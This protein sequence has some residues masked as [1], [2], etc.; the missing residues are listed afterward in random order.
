[1]GPGRKPERW[2]SHDAA[3]MFSHDRGHMILFSGYHERLNVLKYTL[4]KFDED[5]QK[6]SHLDPNQVDRAGDSLFHLVAK[7]K[8]NNMVLS[9]TELLCKHNLSS[10]VY[11][12]DQKLPSFYIKKQND[13]RLPFIKL[14][15]KALPKTSG[16]KRKM[17][18]ENNGDEN[19][20]NENVN[21]DT[22]GQ[23]DIKEVIRISTQR[24]IRKKKIEESIR[25]LPDSKISIF[26]LD[27]SPTKQGPEDK[28]SEKGDNSLDEKDKGAKMVKKSLLTE[29][30]NGQS[31]TDVA[32]SKTGQKTQ[33]K[34]EQ[35][36]GQGQSMS[37]C[38][39][40]YVKKDKVDVDRQVMYD[41]VPKAGSELPP[42]DVIG[43]ANSDRRC[44]EAVDDVTDDVIESDESDTE[45]T[46]EEFVI[47]VQVKLP[48][49][50][51]FNPFV[52][53]GFSLFLI[54]MSPISFLG[55]LRFL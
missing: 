24:E 16:P 37:G 5:Q 3:H 12:N 32:D 43:V 28:V 15:A 39:D 38:Q 4:E 40:E 45:E 47:D 7:A 54:W 46:E 53:N 1:M 21:G 31:M 49:S 35:A 51:A 14:A 41:Q 27:A 33:I 2:F 19:Q 52:T 23:H 34:V 8:Y 48:F 17:E 36:K 13:R 30:Q 20:S 6:F 26:N 9:A 11:N 50:C 42:D 29:F 22:E 18:K 55:A 25:L 10:S 44:D